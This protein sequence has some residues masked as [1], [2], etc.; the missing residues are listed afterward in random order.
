[1][2]SQARRLRER[3]EVRTKILDAARELFSA[4]GFEAVK[5]RDIAH[6]ID[7]TPAA[8]YFHFQDKEA[9]LR[10]LCDTDFRALQDALRRIAR[11]PDPIERLR[12]MGR[13]YFTFALEHPNH[14]RL[15]FMTPTPHIDWRE[16]DLQRGNPEEDAYAF[17]KLT[18]AEGIAQGRFR[19]E[20]NDPDLLAQVIWSAVHGIAS[21]YVCKADDPWIEWRPVRKT[22]NLLIDTVIRG[23]VRAPA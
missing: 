2:G 9:L 21:L 23:L 15:M 20:L 10:E 22:V 19:P 12:R 18:L 1:M 13:A 5:M 4:Q 7:Y 14:Y 11:H 8:I 17:L 3:E 16:R 6:K